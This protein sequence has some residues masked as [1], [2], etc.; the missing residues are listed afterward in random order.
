M[1]G[2]EY[3]SRRPE[4]KPPQNGRDVAVVRADQQ[5]LLIH[6]TH[7][8]S[9]FITCVEQPNMTVEGYYEINPAG[10]LYDSWTHIHQNDP[11]VVPNVVAGLRRIMEENGMSP[12]E[13]T[14]VGGAIDKLT[15]V[16]TPKAKDVPESGVVFS[17]VE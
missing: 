17:I 9:P 5:G 10:E 7:G 15:T 1:G 6:F 4:V 2:A 8:V 11:S 3:I 14:V 13:K 16:V 12:T